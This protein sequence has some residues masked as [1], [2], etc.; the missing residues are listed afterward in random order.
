MNIGVKVMVWRGKGRMSHR[1]GWA[2]RHEG[3]IFLIFFW[4]SEWPSLLGER[5]PV[6]D[7]G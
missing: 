1:Y 5:I 6:H 3:W 2:W 4:H 7:V